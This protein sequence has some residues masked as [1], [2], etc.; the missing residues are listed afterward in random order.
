MSVEKQIGHVVF[1][2]DTGIGL[3]TPGQPGVEA[4]ADGSMHQVDDVPGRAHDNPL[5]TGV[6][7]AAHG[8]DAGDGSH[9]GDDFRGGVFQGLIDED[10]LGPSAS[11]FGRIFFQQLFFDVR[12][13]PLDE[14]FFAVAILFSLGAQ[15][16]D[17]VPDSSFSRGRR[18]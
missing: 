1:T 17:F 16:I 18:A 4:A 15:A 12:G 14:L 2:V 8:D 6:G 7:A 9:I 10:L 11:H 13:F 5:A 3:I